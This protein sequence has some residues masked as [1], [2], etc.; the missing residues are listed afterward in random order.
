[1]NQGIKKSAPAAGTAKGADK[2]TIKNNFT[3]QFGNPQVVRALCVEYLFKV[4]EPKVL[5]E[6]LTV[7]KTC[8]DSSQQAASNTAEQYRLRVVQMLF[9][10]DGEQNV[11]RV[12]DFV[13]R[14]F[15]KEGANNA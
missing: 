2:K 13:Y 9:N 1:M 3:T 14:T 11:R 15:L 10:I 8:G 7:I 5:A 12:Y 6:L 4:Y